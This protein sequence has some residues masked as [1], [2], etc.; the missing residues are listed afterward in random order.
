MFFKKKKSTFIENDKSDLS[1]SDV[2]PIAEADVYLAYGRKSQA[3][4]ILNEALESGRLSPERHAN[5][6]KEKT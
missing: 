1:L 3:L 5:F 2:D 4:S 6:L